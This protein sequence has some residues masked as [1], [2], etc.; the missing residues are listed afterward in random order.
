MK[1]KCLIIDDEPLA[2]KV[3]ENYINRIDF[4]KLEGSYRSAIDAFNHLGKDDIDLL[5][6][7]IQMPQ[8]TGIEFLRTLSQAPQIIFTTA[9]REHA[10]ESYELNA[11]DYLVKPIAFERFLM[12]VRKM[13]SE[14]S[15]SSTP[16]SSS[17]LINSFIYLK[18]E[19]KVFKILF[20]NILYVESFKDYIVLHTQQGEALTSY[21]S[22]SHLEKSLPEEDFLRIHRSYLINLEHIHSFSSSFIH[23][24]DKELPI[25]RTYKEQVQKIL[26]I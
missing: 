6:L 5:F 17:E 20:K 15:P 13:I 3:I 14:P 10:V 9:S 26:D 1:F 11:L 4:L 8:L 24:A 12:A 16:L 7:D 2:I 18:A 25:G 22:L 23:I 21:Q 19:N